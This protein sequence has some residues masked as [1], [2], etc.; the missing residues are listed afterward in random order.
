MRHRGLEHLIGKE[1]ERRNLLTSD[2][3]GTS[4]PGP[5]SPTRAGATLEYPSAYPFP[6][7]PARPGNLAL[8]QRWGHLLLS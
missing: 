8:K 1:W 4:R 2:A 6:H 7:V 5:H 3:E